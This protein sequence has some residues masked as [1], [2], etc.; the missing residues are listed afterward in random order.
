MPWVSCCTVSFAL[1][2]SSPLPK[3][4]F[5]RSF[6]IFFSCCSPALV[7]FLGISIRLSS[8]FCW[9]V[10]FAS[11]YNRTYIMLI[12]ISMTSCVLHVRT[13]SDYEFANALNLG[14]KKRICLS[15]LGIAV[16]LT[17]IEGSSLLVP[18]AA[19]ADKYWEVGS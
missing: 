7:V 19:E 3:A 14:N 8:V 2:F 13:G 6:L 16:S 15:G 18:V 5:R 10:I 11:M 1:P 9:L 4:A 17:E 12:Y